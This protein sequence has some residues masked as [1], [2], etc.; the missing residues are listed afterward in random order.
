ML[1]EDAAFSY[2]GSEAHAEDLISLFTKEAAFNY[3]G[4]EVEDDSFAIGH[5]IRLVE[6]NSPGTSVFFYDR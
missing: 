6:D 5:P 2:T 1:T 4:S 3:A